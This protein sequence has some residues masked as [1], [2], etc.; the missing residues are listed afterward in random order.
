MLTAPAVHKQASCFQSQRCPHTF[1][2]GSPGSLMNMHFLPLTLPAT[3]NSSPM[4]VHVHTGWT[5]KAA[6]E[7][8]CPQISETARQLSRRGVPLI[9]RLLS[10]AN[11]APQSDNGTPGFSRHG[12]VNT[13]QWEKKRTTGRKEMK[14][15]VWVMVWTGGGVSHFSCHKM[16]LS[17]QR[18]NF[19]ANRDVTND[20]F[21]WRLN[22]SLNLDYKQENTLN[23]AQ[24]KL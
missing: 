19:A 15:G 7:Q 6:N 20:L 18:S 16:K 4:C 10:A 14:E 11:G 3:V 22:G 9:G 1:F 2:S 17:V 24:F 8:E 13:V 21:H 23:W 5:T 12:C